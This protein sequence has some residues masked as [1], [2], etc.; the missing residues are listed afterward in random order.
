MVVTV[1]PPDAHWTVEFRDILKP[2]P[3]DK[4]ANAGFKVIRFLY[5]PYALGMVDVIPVVKDPQ[6]DFVSIFL[7]LG[8]AFVLGLLLVYVTYRCKLPVKPS[9]PVENRQMVRRGFWDDPI[10]IDRMPDPPIPTRSSGGT[11]GAKYLRTLY[12]HSR[13]AAERDSEERVHRDVNEEG[14][15]GASHVR[16]QSADPSAG[17]SADPS[18]VPSASHSCSPIGSYQ[19]TT[20]FP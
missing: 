14:Q 10:V 15:P 6:P 13:Q 1:P 3:K 11:T 2:F 9:L 19:Q 5:P 8:I 16:S 4:M 12:M 20:D 7:A 17:P 18:A